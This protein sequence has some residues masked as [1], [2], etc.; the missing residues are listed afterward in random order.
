MQIRGNTQ[1]KTKTVTLD[2]ID[3]SVFESGQLY[4]DKEDHTS[5][6]NGSKVSFVLNYECVPGSEH[7]FLRGLL[8]KSGVDYTLE[9]D[10]KT[11]TFTQAPYTG[12]ELVISYRKKL[13]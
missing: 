11:I 6:C 12:D 3:N 10:N 4:I 7:V 1:I 2:E 9:I 5:E 8:R 13:S